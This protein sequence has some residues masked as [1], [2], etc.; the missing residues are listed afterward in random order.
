MRIGNSRAG[1]SI[2]LAVVT[3]TSLALLSGCEQ[4]QAPQPAGGGDVIQDVAP[5]DG[6][7]IDA[8]SDAAQDSLAGTDASLDSDTGSLSDGGAETDAV[9]PADALDG[10]AQCPS[11][12]P[13][14]NG[15]CTTAG[16]SCNFGQ[17][18]CCG[19]C[20]PSLVCQCTGATWACYYTDACMMG[21]GACPDAIDAGPSEV[22]Q[23]DAVPGDSGAQPDSGSQPDT[24][25]QP[26]SESS[27]SLIP[28]ATDQYCAKPEGQCASI[29]KCKM[30]PTL[31]TKEL[32]QQCGC[33][34]VTYANPCFAAA[35]GRAIQYAG[36]CKPVD[37]CV[38]GENSCA[39]GEYCAAPQGQCSGTGQCTAKAQMCPM[40]YKPVCGC[41]GKTYGNGCSAS[42]SGI[43]VAFDGECPEVPGSCDADTNS[44]CAKSQFCQAPAGQCGGK[45]QCKPYPQGCMEVWAPVCGCDGKTYGNDCEA[46]AKGVNVNS[47][48]ECTGKPLSQF[49]LTCGAPVCKGWSDKGI[50]LCTSGQQLNASCA[51]VGETCDPQDACNAL[52][53]CALSDPKLELGGCPK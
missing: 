8:V 45:G 48:G 20:N 29:G 6:A 31:C 12:A 2:A 24:G 19:K 35:A 27:S 15:T 43:V 52:L 53:K 5:S 21:P 30:K 13:N 14:P 51:N 23:P 25:N 49:Y 3:G 17:E 50:P 11:E 22:S 1:W 9:A 7:A 26:C 46:L 47:K 33:D 39:P 41:D 4:A 44:G 28:C 37:G 18:C 16:L 40:V 36:P 42:S 34:N 38:V 32:N 10:S